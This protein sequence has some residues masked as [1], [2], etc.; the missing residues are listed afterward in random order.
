MLPKFDMS[1]HVCMWLDGMGTCQ[2]QSDV[3]DVLL[4]HW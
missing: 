3:S 4:Q 1:G 2:R